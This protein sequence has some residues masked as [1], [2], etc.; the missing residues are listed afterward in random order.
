MNVRWSIRRPAGGPGR[1]G[2]HSSVGYRAADSRG[3]PQTSVFDSAPRKAIAGARSIG[4][5]WSDGREGQG[6]GRLTGRSRRAH[7][8]RRSAPWQERAMNRDAAPLREPDR[9]I[10]ARRRVRAAHA[11]ASG[12]G[13]WL[14]LGLARRAPLQRV[15][16]LRVAGPDAGRPRARNQTAAA[17]YG[18]GRAAPEPPAARSRGR[19]SP[20]SVRK[21]SRAV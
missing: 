8:L 21:A 6:C 9:E 4:A 14:R 3:R 7:A 2:E 17:R 13:L 11:D 20:C 12:R 19:H 10:G 5:L 16:L 1:R 18:R 15:R